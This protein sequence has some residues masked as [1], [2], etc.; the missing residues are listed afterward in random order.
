MSIPSFYGY[1]YLPLCPLCIYPSKDP[2]SSYMTP[3]EKTFAFD[4][5]RVLRHEPVLNKFRLTA[6][7]THY[8][9]D[10][11][12]STAIVSLRREDKPKAHRRSYVDRI[13]ARTYSLDYYDEDNSAY[14]NFNLGRTYDFDFFATVMGK[15]GPLEIW[16]A[17][18]YF[19]A[20][21]AA[22]CTVFRGANLEILG[23]RAG[24]YKNP[25][26]AIEQID[27]DDDEGGD[28]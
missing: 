1:P 7:A 14:L 25:T 21:E 18:N 28:D 13:Y 6:N 3:I 5:L 17:R 27:G 8:S 16:G 11:V 19:P 10:A 2:L 23:L 26:L 15:I 20:S 9:G 12:S 24:Y 4:M 22:S